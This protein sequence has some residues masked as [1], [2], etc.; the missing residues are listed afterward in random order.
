MSLEDFE[1]PLEYLSILSR[2]LLPRELLPRE[3]LPFLVVFLDRRH[4]RFH[5]NVYLVFVPH[6]LRVLFVVHLDAPLFLHSIH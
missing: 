6:P 1:L 2:E 3:L 4:R 5:H